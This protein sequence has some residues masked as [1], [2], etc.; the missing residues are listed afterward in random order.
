[1]KMMLRITIRAIAP[2]PSSHGERYQTS[3]AGSCSTSAASLGVRPQTSP[4][5]SSSGLGGVASETPTVTAA[6]AANAMIAPQKLAASSEPR[7]IVPHE[8]SS[9]VTNAPRKPAISPQNPAHG[10]DRFQN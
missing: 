10:V 2:A 8:Y 1:M 3:S 4:R 9:C 7:L 6:S 5:S